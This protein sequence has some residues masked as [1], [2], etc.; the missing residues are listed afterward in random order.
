MRIAGSE[1]LKLFSNKIFLICIIAF[2]CADSLF[3]VMLQSSDYENSAISSDVGAYEQLIRECNGA[4]DK[5]AFFESKNTEIQ[6]AQIL[7]HNGNA[8][9]YRKKY[10]KLYDNAAGLDLNDDELFNRSVM[11]SN[12]QAQLSHIDSYE[13]FISNMKSRAEQQSS[14]SIF[15]EP[16]SFSFR[17][18]EKTPMDFAEVKGVKP[19]LGNNKAVEAATSYEVSSY[20]LLIIVLLVN[21][22]MFSVER[23]KGLYVLVR[24]TAKGRLSTIACKLLVVLSVTAVVSLLF[25]ASNIM[26]AG[27]IL[28]VLGK[29]L[30]LCS[31][32][33]LTAFLFVVIK[34]SAKT[35][36]ILAA[37]L[38]FEF[39]CFIFIDGSSVLASLKFINIFYLISGN[40]IFGCYQNVNIFSQPIN[41]ITIFI[42]LA[43]AL[44]VV[45]VFGTTLAFSRLSQHNGKLV[46]L[47]RLMSRLGRFKK[48]NGSVRIYSGEAYK[49]YKTSFALVAVI[50]LVAL[51]FVSYNDDLSIIFISPQESAYD[52]YMQ[53]L[54]GELDEEKY[55]FIESERAYFEE[56]AREAEEI[57][58][59]NTISAEE[60]TNRLN[61]IDGILSIRGMAFEDICAQLEYVNGKAELTG[62][63][64]ALVNEVVNKRLTMDT[65]REW[66]Y[67]ALLLAVVIFC[68]SNI[69]AIEYKTSMVNL[70][71]ANKHGKARLLIIKLLTVLITTVISYILIYLPYMLNFIK[72]FGTASFD[73][74]LAYSRDFSALTSGI[75]VGGYILALGFDHLLAAVGATALVYLLSYIF[76]NQFVT[77]IISSGLLLIPCVVFIDNS[78]IRMV[79]AFSNNAQTAV[80]GIIT[81][82][83]LLIIAVSALIIFV[84][85]RKSTKFII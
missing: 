31:L 14:F 64:P 46:L 73:L 23:E 6:I 35:Y 80:I 7:L 47:D 10:P 2:F 22:L 81:A 68:T 5:N 74:P 77:M 82:V 20:I 36:L 8:D 60:K 26:M 83:C 19:I 54:E 70:I 48:I 9:V 24:S 12:I 40:N 59:D 25:Y 21:I 39:S 11:L 72:T 58:A 51:G 78:K 57:S 42:G 38:I 79:S 18:I 66:E 29:T 32:S 45:G 55:D 34:S 43:I 15:A 3:F 75:T 41:I 52:T 50:I 4:E 67:F 62:E 1:Y 27:T 85:K 33:M 28:W 44:F 76:K 65:F 30:L 37:A 56:L 49:H 17:N 61:T 63:K 69:L 53:T 84:P 13:E 16:D 71:S